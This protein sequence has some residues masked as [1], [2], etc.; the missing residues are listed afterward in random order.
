MHTVSFGINYWS[1]GTMTPLFLRHEGY[2][3]AIGAFMQSPRFKD[4][5]V[6]GENFASSSGYREKSAPEGSVLSIYTILYSWK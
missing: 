2:L 5:N 6:W 3:G 1:K 4:S